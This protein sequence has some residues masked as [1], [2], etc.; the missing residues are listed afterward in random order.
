MRKIYAVANSNLNAKNVIDNC[1]SYDS[2]WQKHGHTSLYGIG[3]VIEVVTGLV[4]DL[5][6]LSKYHECISS[7]YRQKRKAK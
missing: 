7:E 5:E 2:T 4:V 3:I 1:V 6:I